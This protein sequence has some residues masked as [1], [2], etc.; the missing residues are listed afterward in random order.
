MH[1]D[2]VQ[3][4]PMKRRVGPGA[5]AALHMLAQLCVSA[6]LCVRVAAAAAP[7][8]GEFKLLALNWNTW[9]ARAGMTVTAL[10]SN[11]YLAG[12]EGLTV[13]SN[14][15]V[16]IG[17]FKQVFASSDGGG[18]RIS[19]SALPPSLSAAL[20][21]LPVVSWS[22]WA[23]MPAARSYHCAATM[24][25]RLYVAAG[26]GDVE[27]EQL[28]ADMWWLSGS[29]AHRT[30]LAA[31][32]VAFSPAA[33]GCSLA[34]GGSPHPMEASLRC[35]HR[36]VRQL[37]LAG[38]WHRARGVGRAAGGAVGPV[39]VRRQCVAGGAH[40]AASRAPHMRSRADAWEEVEAVAARFP[41]TGHTMLHFNQRLLVIG[42]G[43][44][45]PTSPFYSRDVYRSNVSSPHQGKAYRAD[46]LR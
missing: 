12:G 1:H 42:G 43:L 4:W 21:C 46:S 29:C 26:R 14:G 10:G 32:A 9:S 8:V 38:R 5:P 37:H 44:A 23:D 20:T 45:T 16:G 40:A 34:R 13:L 3:S 11:M 25:G 7:E 31:R 30:R 27:N 28:F 22:R 2:S 19:L 18:I 6:F 39:A 33:A 24:G 36:I 41:R 35:R 15:S 17:P